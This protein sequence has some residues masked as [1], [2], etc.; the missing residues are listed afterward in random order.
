M[1]KKRGQPKVRNWQAVA[2]HMRSSAGAM[3]GTARQKNKRDRR[4]AK[5]DLR[6][7]Q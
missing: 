1:P 3:G 4:A 7:R 2:A 5:Q 6:A